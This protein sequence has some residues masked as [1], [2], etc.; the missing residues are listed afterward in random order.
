MD[1]LANLKQRW[2]GLDYPFLIH[3]NGELSFN[4]IS[5]HKAIEL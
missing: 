3:S 4:A 2:E 1:I 5:E